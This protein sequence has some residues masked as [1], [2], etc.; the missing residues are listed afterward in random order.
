MTIK[1]VS[2]IA[3]WRDS[4]SSKENTTAETA[5]RLVLTA[6]NHAQPYT[7]FEKEVT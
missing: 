4:I 5:E 3:V 2:V 1:E 7:T 6:V